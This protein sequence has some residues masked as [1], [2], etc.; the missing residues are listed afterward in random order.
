[1]GPNQLFGAAPTAAGM[2]GAANGTVRKMLSGLF[3]RAQP[4]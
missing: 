4:K 1:M 3:H 2:L